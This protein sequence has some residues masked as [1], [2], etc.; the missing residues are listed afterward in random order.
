MLELYVFSIAHPLRLRN[1]DPR[2][3]LAAEDAYY[4]S[5]RQTPFKRLARFWRAL[6]GAGADQPRAP[7]V[8]EVVAG[9]ASAEHAHGAEKRDQAAGGKAERGGAPD[10]GGIVFLG[11]D[12]GFGA[13]VTSG[14]GHA[15][16]PKSAVQNPMPLTRRACPTSCDGP[17]K[18]AQASHYDAPGTLT[19]P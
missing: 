12:D 13:G 10:D 8:S 15:G 9:L 7:D 5:Y 4:A 17:H 19:I 6:R 18:S 11:F 14:T 3:V 16:H 1:G 2:R